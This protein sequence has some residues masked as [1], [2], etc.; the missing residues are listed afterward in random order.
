[1]L[2]HR[3]LIKTESRLIIFIVRQRHFGYMDVWNFIQKLSL[4]VGLFLRGITGSEGV[5]EG[6]HKVHVFFIL[7]QWHW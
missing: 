4:L 3:L 1:M 5:H 7:Y 2:T 6:A